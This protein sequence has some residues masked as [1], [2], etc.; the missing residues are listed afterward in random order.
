MH[1]G[2]EGTNG[3]PTYGDPVKV[4]CREPGRGG[5]VEGKRGAAMTDVLL[6]GE[7]QRQ[8]TENRK[9]GGRTGLGGGKER[10]SLWLGYTEGGA[11]RNVK[12]AVGA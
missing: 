1:V 3:M 12:Q 2:T 5:H 10:V 9:S 8:L 4:G 11:D 7:W 6:L